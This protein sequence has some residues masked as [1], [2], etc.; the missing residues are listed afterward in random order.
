MSTS[1]TKVYQVKNSTRRVKLT[2]KVGHGQNAVSSIFL[3][4]VELQSGL[5]DG[6]EKLD[7]GSGADLINKNL[8]C[9]TTV[10]DVRAETNRT[11]VSYKLTGGV[12]SF[13]NTYSEAVTHE[14]ETLSY[15]ATFFF[16]A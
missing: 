16:F 3:G 14:G 2:I 15:M 6:V 5:R 9:T 1:I 13:Q 10:T 12:K 8:H 7:L 11:S 4:G